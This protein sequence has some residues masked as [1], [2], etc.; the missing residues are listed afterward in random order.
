MKGIIAGIT[1]LVG[2]VL[3]L[4]P[5]RVF[6]FYGEKNGG[7]L[8]SGLSLTALYSVFAGLYVGFAVLGLVIQEDPQ[9]KDAVVS[10]LSTSVPGLI[11]TPGGSGAIDL[12]ALFASRVLSWS[13][14]VAFVLV[15]V[16]A[17]SWFASARAAVRALFE[18]PGDTTF[19]LLLKL[20]D[21][22]LVVAFGVVT[23][24]SAALSVFSTSALSFFFGLVGID[25]RSAFAVIV[26]RIV[27]LLLVL[28][29]D[30]AVLAA[31]FRMLI[32]T[33]I[34]FRRLLGGALIGGIGLGVLKALGAT[35]VGG[36]S[37]NPLLASFAIILG[38]LIWFG[39]ICQVILLSA[40]WIAVGLKDRGLSLRIPASA[41]SAQVPP[42][43][44]R[45]R[46]RAVS[47]P[48]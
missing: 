11:K 42:A 21:L 41:K 16:T 20:K 36:A 48:G 13:S 44:S 6:L 17:L 33:P 34:P 24:L 47:P 32:A 5:V 26:A 14:I 23:L 10:T 18:L 1:S 2:R 39:L 46:T 8:A 35:I 25:H 15:L 3:K 22:G 7:I 9:F 38:L 28:A 27:G 37:K 19:F 40:A 12:G 30:T 29:I 4:R 45:P 43:H 31:L